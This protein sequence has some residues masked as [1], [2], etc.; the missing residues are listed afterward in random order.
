MPFLKVKG[1][2]NIFI[3]LRAGLVF[4]NFNGF[5]FFQFDNSIL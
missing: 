2:L 5:I 1:K 4:I 3:I